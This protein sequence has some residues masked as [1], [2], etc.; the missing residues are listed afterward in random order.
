MDRDIEIK[1]IENLK[2]ERVDEIL[3][4]SSIALFCDQTIRNL[5]DHYKDNI[6]N[7]IKEKFMKLGVI[8]GSNLE[9]QSSN[10]ASGE[11]MEVKS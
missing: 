2:K 7:S 3:K 8:G 10:P 6:V 9:F 1:Q 5:F 4:T 11:I